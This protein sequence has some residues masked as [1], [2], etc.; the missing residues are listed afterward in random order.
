MR[1][2][3][4]KSALV[5]LAMMMATGAVAASPILIHRD[6]G[7]GC[8]EKWA[9]QVRAQFGRPVRIVDDRSRAAFQRARGVPS[10]LSSCH[11]AVIDGLVF[12]GHVPV[13]DMKRL[14]AQRPRGVS[15]LAVS[16]MPIGSPGMEVPGQQAQPYVVIAFGPSGQRIFARH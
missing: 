13:A 8:C 1:A 7:C 2:I 14:L 3:T 9:E 11:T 10:R 4:I 5:S 12:E 6:P 16:G 15:G